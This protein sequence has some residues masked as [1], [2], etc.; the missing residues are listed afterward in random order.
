[1]SK[2]SPEE[3]ELLFTRSGVAESRFIFTPSGSSEVVR[4]RVDEDVVVNATPLALMPV[5]VEPRK[6][7]E[8][9]PDWFCASKS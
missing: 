7:S 5:V 3:K 8:L 6:L 2:S 1:M 4:V 9:E